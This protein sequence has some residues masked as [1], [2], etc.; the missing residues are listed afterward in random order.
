M[1]NKILSFPKNFNKDLEG[2]FE[3]LN[4]SPIKKAPASMPPPKTPSGTN[5]MIYKNTN[6]PQIAPLITNP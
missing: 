4:M 1:N 6:L 5:S 2:I 3:G